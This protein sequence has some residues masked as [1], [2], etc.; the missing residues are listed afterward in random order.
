MRKRCWCAMSL[1]HDSWFRCKKFAQVCL[2]GSKLLTGWVIQLN[3]LPNILGYISSDKQSLGKHS[4]GTCSWV[5][6]S[7]YVCIETIWVTSRNSERNVTVVLH[8][9]LS[10]DPISLWYSYR[11][12]RRII[13]KSTVRWRS[14]SQ[15]LSL[16]SVLFYWCLCISIAVNDK[17]LG[18]KRADGKLKP[19]I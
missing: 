5:T 2:S 13:V 3:L 4:S 14:R 12:A 17:I 8:V 16:D 19:T 10:R 7:W 18:S 1:H 11:Q 6:I 9:S 15:G